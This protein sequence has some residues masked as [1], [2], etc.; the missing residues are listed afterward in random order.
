MT[1]ILSD[2]VCLVPDWPAP[3][4]V[5]SLSTTRRGGISL[6]KYSSLNLGDHV[7]DDPQAVLA[8]RRWLADRVSG[9]P[10]W[11]NQ[12]HGTTV[13]D[14]AAVAAGEQRPDADAAFAYQAGVICTVMTADCLP[15]LL[16]DDRGRVVA[17]A[18]AGWRGLLDG[19][20][21]ATVAAMAI[22]GEHLLA[23]L[24]PAIGPMA[25]EVGDEVRLAFVERDAG[26]TAAFV[27]APG[28]KWLADIFMLASQRLAACGVERV[29]GGNHCTVNDPERFFSY[30][31]DGQTG[32]MATMVWLER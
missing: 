23:W 9:E 2:G 14:A 15:V 11:L 24:G 29:F 13:V 18:H 27:P 10:C 5:R 12:V 17:A 1:T 30:R 16:C 4:G 26:A 19:V 7:G 3:S 28:D 32:R 25:F 8:N 22:P 6:G 20:L 31:R 21:E